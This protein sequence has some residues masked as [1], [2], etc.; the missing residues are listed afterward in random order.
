MIPDLKIH[1][2][3]K[4]V[5]GKGTL[6]QLPDEITALSCSRV[7]IVTISP[8]LTQLNPLITKLEARNMKVFVNMSIMN[9]PSFAE[10][11][12]MMDEVRPFNPDLVLGIGGGS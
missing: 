9:E 7:L 4:L 10:V 5:F 6:D 1:F 2:P 8:L 12:Q 3:G 11:K